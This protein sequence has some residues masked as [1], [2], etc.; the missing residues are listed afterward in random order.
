MVPVDLNS[1][2]ARDLVDILGMP[3]ESAKAV[4]ESRPFTTVDEIVE[5][6]LID[7]T[8]L[9][10]TL[11]NG[12]VLKAIRQTRAIDINGSTL[13]D[14]TKI[15]LDEVSAKRILMGKPFRSWQELDEYACLPDDRWQLL[16]NTFFLGPGT[17]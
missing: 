8:T 7:R 12:A 1:A 9:D 15:G 17:S 14:L 2:P 13:E 4:A 11:K 6:R 10:K 5:R 16:R 3:K